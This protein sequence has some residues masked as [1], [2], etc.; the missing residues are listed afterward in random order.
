[1]PTTGIAIGGTPVDI[2]SGLTNDTAY[3]VQNLEEAIVRLYEKSGSDAPTDAERED[4]GKLMP[5]R[6]TKVTPESGSA[7]WAWCDKA[8]PLELRSRLSISEAG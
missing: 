6:A 5:F 2:T 4:A 3:S 8:G 1:M 7:V